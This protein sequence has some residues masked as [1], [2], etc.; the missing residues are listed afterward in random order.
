MRARR[1][2]FVVS[3]V[4]VV[5]LMTVGAL[6]DSVG[7]I[8]FEGYSLG[9]VWGQNGWTGGYCGP[10]DIQVVDNS[11]YPGAPAS[12][13]TK[14]LRISNSTVNGCFGDSFTTSL[15]DEAGEATAENGGFSGGT[16][17]PKFVGQ[18]TFASTTGG[19]QP[20]ASIQISPDRGDGARMSYLQMTHTAT[21]LDFTFID[22]QGT[23]G[24]PPPCLGCANFVDT[25][26]GGYNP[27]VP[28]TVRLVMLLNDG[29]SNDVVK[30]YI[31][32]SL[33]HTGG[34]WEDYYTMDTESSPNPPRVSR[35]VDSL[36]IRAKG[37]AAPSVAGQGFLIDA[38]SLLSGPAT[39]NE[40]PSG[41]H[42]P[43][44][45]SAPVHNV[46][47]PIVP[48]LTSTIHDINCDVVVPL[49]L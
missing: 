46:V 22:V 47:E 6:A 9:D 8:N 40:D 1:A 18:L 48:P 25:T 13:G 34:S 11:L 31:D 7:P 4:S 30:V 33:V 3:V 38:I 49:G 23:D 20:G 29:P 16:R 26:F 36:L 41:S 5:T 44:V 27:S 45:V 14:S 2:L 15:A 35:T 24:T 12:F 42:E 19:L 10:H 37:P 32:G 17:Q 21:A 39:C 28:H 43:G